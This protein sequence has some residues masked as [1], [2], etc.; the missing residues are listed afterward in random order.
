VPLSRRS[1]LTKLLREVRYFTY[2]SE[3]SDAEYDVP[4][5][6]AE[7]FRQSETFRV[8]IGNLQLITGKYNQV[9]RPPPCAQREVCASCRRVC[10]AGHVWPCVCMRL[11]H[12]QQRLTDVRVRVRQML[13]TLLDVERPLLERE[14][15]AMDVL[16]EQGLTHLTWKSN[17]VQL[18]VRQALNE[19]RACARTADAHAS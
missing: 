16:L 15:K 11:T 8:L 14:L 13:T 10:L 6:A 9:G 5:A 12:A 7:L 1:E 19:V 4:A 2:L 18:Y 17:D 3:S